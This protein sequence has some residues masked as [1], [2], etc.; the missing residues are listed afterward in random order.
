MNH[1][2][3]VVYLLLLLLDLRATSLAASPQADDSYSTRR[4]EAIDLMKANKF[5]DAL[6]VLEKL[7]AE[8]PDDIPVLE[9]LAFAVL[10]NAA[11][12]AD[13]QVRKQERIRARKLAEQAQ[14]L[15]DTSNLLKVLLE[16]PADGSEVKYSEHAEVEAFMRRGE[17]AFAKGDFDAAL[18]AY[19]RALELDPRQYFAAL[20]VGDVYFKQKE[21]EQAER[22]FERAVEINPNT[23]TA[24]RYWGDDL[25]AE[26]KLPEAKVHFV[27]AIVAEPYNR[28][29][30]VG[31][32]QW[33]QKQKLTLAHPAIQPRGTIEDKGKDDKGRSQTNITLD[34]AMLDPNA[35]K[36]GTSAWFA[37]SL[38]RAPWHGEKFQKEFPS[39]KEYRH[40]LR[41]EVEALQGVVD[42]VKEGLKKHEIKQLDPALVT[43]VALSDKGL[44]ESF[45]LISKADAGIVKDYPAYREA[46][47]EHLRQY[48][49]EFIVHP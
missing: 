17:T 33:A 25:I 18:A 1:R 31:L 45:V 23:E 32:I 10:S 46:H 48:I 42:Q 12:I 44:L 29:A 13:E 36:D 20:F 39:E 15:G 28:R 26:N 43:L 4:T 37:Y 14:K 41:E 5:V 9:A 34:P 30:W 22:W 7:H 35:K 19:K 24:H 40:T 47:R 16:E 11:T 38:F 6:P 21:Y 27:D 8:K 3:V 2:R 49:S